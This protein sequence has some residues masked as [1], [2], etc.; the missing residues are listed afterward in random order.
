MFINKSLTKCVPITFTKLTNVINVENYLL[1]LV[2]WQDR[3]NCLWRLQKFHMWMLWKIIYSS[4]LPK[5][6][7]KYHSLRS[8]RF[9]MWLLWK[10][11]PH[12]G[13]MRRNIKTVHEGHKDFK[14]KSWEKSFTPD[15][16]RGH[17]KNIHKGHKHFN[18][19]NVTHVENY[20]YQN[21]SQSSY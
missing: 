16:V 18:F 9:Q 11:F 1:M 5:Q 8:Q 17:T 19:S 20:W 10:N 4:W 12:V 2:I 7:H 15:S 3:S 21:H 13:N 14:C 6:T